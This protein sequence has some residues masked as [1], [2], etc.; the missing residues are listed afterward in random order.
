MDSLTRYV[1]L[2]WRYDYPAAKEKK[3][4]ALIKIQVNI[5]DIFLLQV[6]CD[7]PG[8][9]L[10]PARAVL[11]RPHLA[12]TRQYIFYKRCS[13]FGGGW[14]GLGK[15]EHCADFEDINIFFLDAPEEASGK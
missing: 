11:W 2:D 8:P 10:V 6:Y 1:L 15:S 13:D 12:G 9:C 3:S 7:V 4:I 5:S 14:V